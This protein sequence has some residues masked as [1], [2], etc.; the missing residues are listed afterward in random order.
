M[1]NI[2]KQFI[3]DS[4]K[5]WTINYPY[6]KEYKVDFYDFIKL[7]KEEI[8]KVIN[9]STIKR[10]DELR[11]DYL[12]YKNI[13]GA[14]EEDPFERGKLKSEQMENYNRFY[15]KYPFLKEHSDSILLDVKAFEHITTKEKTTIKRNKKNLNETISKAYNKVDNKN[16]HKDKI[17]NEFE[18]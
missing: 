13:Q 14:R 1:G 4:L 7:P 3:M 15:E 6:P 17:K 2:D 16:T 12:K 9:D 18:R 10:L 11:K 8:N 5:K